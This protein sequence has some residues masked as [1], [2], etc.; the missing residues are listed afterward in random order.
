[1]SALHVALWI[2]KARHSTRVPS[3]YAMLPDELAMRGIAGRL[4][5]DTACDS[6]SPL[7]AREPAVHHH[8]RL[9][10]GARRRVVIVACIHE[11][12]DLVGTM[13]AS[14]SCLRLEVAHR[15][16]LSGT[17]LIIHGVPTPR[18]NRNAATSIM[19]DA[20]SSCVRKLALSIRGANHKVNREFHAPGV[21]CP[22]PAA[23]ATKFVVG[24]G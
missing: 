6:T 12:I 5:E 23:R 8:R 7:L 13:G 14:C 10:A 15:V 2:R 9:F 18:A 3:R 22:Q 20:R 24:R 4:P 19:C 1:M 16:C 11:S 21:G 17:L